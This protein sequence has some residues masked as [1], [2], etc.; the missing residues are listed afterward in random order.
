VSRPRLCAYPRD[1][2]R[3]PGIEIA[4]RSLADAGQRGPRS[5]R[6]PHHGGICGR[7]DR[8]ATHRDAHSAGGSRLCSPLGANSCWCAP[9][10]SG[11]WR[12]RGYLRNR[13]HCRCTHS[14][15]GC[16]IWRSSPCASSVNYPTSHHYFYRDVAPRSG[17]R[18][19]EH[20][21]GISGLSDRSAIGGLI[22][23]CESAKVAINTRR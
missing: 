19:S 9:R 7:A 4:L 22:G 12:R 6:Y 8:S 20:R 10:A 15:A 1:C 3:D 13:G 18:R 14:P 5:D 2:P 21:S 11:V 16:K 23:G 17:R